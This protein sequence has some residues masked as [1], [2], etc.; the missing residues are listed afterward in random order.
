MNVKQLAMIHRIILNSTHPELS[1]ELRKAMARNRK[2]VIREVRSQSTPL[3]EHLIPLVALKRK[4]M[5]HPP[6]W[7][8]E[9]NA[10]L[11]RINAKNGSKSSRKRWLEAGDIE[12]LLNE[13]LIPNLKLSILQK[14]ERE[15][16]KSKPF[17]QKTQETVR[18]YL[19]ELL[20]HT[21]TLKKMNVLLKYEKEPDG[22]RLTLYFG[23][24]K[25]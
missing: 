1:G 6:N 8:D 19:S 24:E 21:A 11:L 15:K 16:G 3:F 14:M 5:P 7:P 20:N 18:K 13:E 22:D 9:I 23:D 12:R 4:N 10:C 2:E 17:S 25:I